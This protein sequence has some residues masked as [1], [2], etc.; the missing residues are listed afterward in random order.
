MYTVLSIPSILVRT[1][2]RTNQKI[3]YG[4][5]LS[6]WKYTFDRHTLYKLNCWQDGAS[7]CVLPPVT[8]SAVCVFMLFVL[9]LA[10]DVDSLLVHDR[11][12]LLD[13]RFSAEDVVKLAD[14]G[15]ETL[16]QL[17]ARVPA[18]MW[19]SPVPLSRRK[20]YCH[21]GKHSSRLVRLK[22]RLVRFSTPAWTEIRAVPSLVIPRHSLAPALLIRWPGVNH[23]NLRPLCR[24]PWTANA[25]DLPVPARISLVNAR[26]LANKT[27][28]LEDFLTSR[29]LDFLCVTETWLS[30]GESSAFTE[31]LPHDCCHFYFLWASGWG[32]GIATI[33]KS[34]YKCKQL[35]LLS[36]FTSFELSLFELG[37]FHTVVCCGPST[38]QVQ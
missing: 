2:P 26:S 31:L 32:G 14:G 10:L 37:R 21:W 7:V 17:L 3:N 38:S 1:E 16:P 25:T 36:S 18:H 8:A 27:F 34:H 35:L 15:R 11:Q 28:V 5:L 33:C 4:Y 13:L 24:A 29:G 23:R 6:E 30:V 12:K 22:A 9:L 20:S 19:H